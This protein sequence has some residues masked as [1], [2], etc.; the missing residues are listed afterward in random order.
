[1]V[2][3]GTCRTLFGAKLGTN[4][5]SIFL[6]ATGFRRESLHLNVNEYG[7]YWASTPYQGEGNNSGYT[8]FLVDRYSVAWN[9]RFMGFAIRPVSD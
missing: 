7:A 6:P 4:G 5:K 9:S 2:L 8:Y 1:M 3:D